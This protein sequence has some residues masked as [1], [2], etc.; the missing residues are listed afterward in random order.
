MPFQKGHSNA[1]RHR[2]GQA[3]DEPDA[4][5]RANGSPPVALAHSHTRP[6]RV[7]THTHTQTDTHTRTRTHTAT[8]CETHTHC[9]ALR[10]V[11]DSGV[12]CCARSIWP[13]LGC[14]GHFLP[15][16][17]RRPARSCKQVRRVVDPSS[18]PHASRRIRCTRR[19]DEGSALEMAYSDGD[20][21]H[22]NGHD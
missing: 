19:P 11:A 3:V 4:G 2:G 14:A 12:A 6:T 16:D 10:S 21:S 5:A 22:S 17:L 7:H 13:L 9:K 18:Q 8:H 20:R 15:S 1:A